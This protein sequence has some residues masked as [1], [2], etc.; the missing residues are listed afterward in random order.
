ME[1]IERYPIFQHEAL[2]TTQQSIRL[3]SIDPELSPEG[4]VQ[5]TMQHATIDA[6][7]NCLSYRWGA[8]D[9][10]HTFLV[11][12]KRLRVNQSLHDFL[13]AVRTLQ[14]P[15]PGRKEKLHLRSCLWI[16]AV[17]IDQTSN[18]EKNHQVAQMGKI[19]SNASKVVMWLGKVP[20][21]GKRRFLDSADE[22]NMEFI[23]HNKYWTRA[24]VAQEVL[25]ARDPVLVVADH[26]IA[27][28]RF[29]EYL[30]DR[31]SESWEMK[32][33]RYQKV[34]LRQ[35]PNPSRVEATGVL[36]AW[37]HNRIMK[38]N[39]IMEWLA[40]MKGLEC[41]ILHDRIFSLRELA[42]EGSRIHVDYSMPLDELAYHVLMA[43]NRNVCL[44]E[45][46]LVAGLLHSVD[47]A[48]YSSASYR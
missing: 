28:P 45:V 38:N 39:S 7:Y 17:C 1:A 9:F 29:V 3:I 27:L 21:S 2:D 41:S 18:H 13:E 36:W 46:I 43:T 40:V 12:G 22:R 30:E 44:C 37:I 48:A 25:L 5:S 47:D 31:P 14:Y 35:A 8:A 15:A 24:W 11:N 42:V 23:L 16:D 32:W 6:H 4:L 19:Y 33:R 10:S 34:V 26:L 20:D